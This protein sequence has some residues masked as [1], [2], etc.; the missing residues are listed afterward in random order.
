MRRDDGR[1]LHTWRAGQA[2]L[3]AYLDDYACL[4]NALV[5]L[6]EATF[7]ERWIDD[8]VSL[9]D[10][11][12]SQFADAEHGGFFFTATDHEKLI[13]RQ[14][15]VQDSSVPSGSAMTAMVLVRLGKLCGRTDYLEA[16]AG[17]LRSCVQLMTKAASF[18]PDAVGRR[19]LPG[20]HA[21]TRA[22]QRCRQCG[23]L[24]D[25]FRPTSPVL[26]EQDRGQPTRHW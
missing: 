15:D 21:G 9:A 6:Y 23:S 19:T 24:H 10:I 1:L 4:I 2:R 5:S 11:V 8:A 13:A 12:L 20:P 22:G 7:D 14:K 16:A 3:D 26:A 18:R 25:S 17:T